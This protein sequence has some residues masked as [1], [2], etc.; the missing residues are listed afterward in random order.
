[1]VLTGRQKATI[2]LSLLGTEVSSEILKFL[3]EDL[4]DAITSGM[5]N[6]PAPSPELISS[7]LEEFSGF[8][9]LPSAQSASA[10]HNSSSATEQP[11]KTSV[12]ETQRSPYD[13]LF[14]SQPR[15]IAA[16]LSAERP[17][18]V[19][20]VL[21][22]LPEVQRKEALSYMI[23]RK[24]ELEKMVKSLKSTPIKE[25]I[26]ENTVKILSGRLERLSLS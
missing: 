17:W 14:Y 7:V 9:T 8:M 20:F 11:V 19:A 21:S 5:N 4:S 18:V 15:K 10:K 25:H 12:Q 23:E 6:L 3:P 22:I 16:A 1:M 2:L 13:I 26:K 24:N